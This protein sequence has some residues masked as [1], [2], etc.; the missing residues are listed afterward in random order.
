MRTTLISVLAVLAQWGI[1][2]NAQSQGGT[3]LATP[4]GNW[5]RPTTNRV[6]FFTSDYNKAGQAPTLKREAAAPGSG[7]F[8]RNFSTTAPIP[9]SS[10]PPNP[11]FSPLVLRPLGSLPPENFRRLLRPKKLFFFSKP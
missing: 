6:F 11:K 10:P 8:V 1:P 9:R 7:G 3:S 5:V 4:N 2:A